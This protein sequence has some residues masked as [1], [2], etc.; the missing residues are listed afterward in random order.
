MVAFFTALLGLDHFASYPQQL[1]LGAATALVL[2]LAC[3]TRSPEL[4]AQTLVVVGVATC[5]EIVGSILWGV[6]RYRLGNLPAF[7]PPAH[8]LVYLTGFSLSRTWLVRRFPRAFA[9]AALAGAAGWGLAGLTVL[10]RQDVV[11][12]VGVAVFALFLLR[13]R[14]PT[15]LAGVFFAVAALEL[16]GTAIGTWRWAAVVPGT[17]LTDGNPPSGAAC[18]YVLFDLVAIALAPQLLAALAAARTRTRAALSGAAA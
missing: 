14:A 15:V 17:R 11:G 9:A 5:F 13:G 6:Y 8:G 2:V 3:R 1:G 18:G 12:A 4:R 10:P 7:V 16:Y